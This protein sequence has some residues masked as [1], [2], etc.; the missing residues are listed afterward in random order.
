MFQY[1]A[2][3]VELVWTTSRA[4]TGVLLLLAIVSGLVPGAIA[5]VGRWLVDAVVAAAGHGDSGRVVRY[6]LYE[7]GLVVA[8]AAAQRGDRDGAVAAC[9]RSS[10][11]ASTC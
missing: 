3:A 11:T 6:V 1:S 7:G 4:L 9:A 10:A 5:Y 8:M 2:R